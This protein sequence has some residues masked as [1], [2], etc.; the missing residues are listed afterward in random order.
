MGRLASGGLPRRPELLVG[1]PISRGGG[2]PPECFLHRV[3]RYPVVR[4]LIS[5]T[6]TTGHSPDA[7][8]KVPELAPNP[9][10]GGRGG[11]CEAAGP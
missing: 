1:L 2:S 3:L 7:L 9:A 6:G 8:A 10:R 11:G 5:V 4:Q